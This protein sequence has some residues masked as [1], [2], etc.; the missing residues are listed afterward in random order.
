[1]TYVNPMVSRYPVGN[2]LNLDFPDNSF[3]RGNIHRTLCTCFHP[4]SCNELL[5]KEMCR[6]CKPVV[7]LSFPEAWPWIL[8]QNPK[9]AALIRLPFFYSMSSQQPSAESAANP[10]WEDLPQFEPVD[11]NYRRPPLYY[12]ICT[13]PVTGCVFQRRSC[14]SM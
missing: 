9:T 11:I 8:W 10:M 5:L 6:V 4:G 3:D 12:F 13:D 14:Y 2:A 1:M 7:R